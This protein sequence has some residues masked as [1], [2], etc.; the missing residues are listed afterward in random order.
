MT[1]AFQVVNCHEKPESNQVVY[2]ILAD[3][4]HEQ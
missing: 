2:L 4:S 1:L 3:N